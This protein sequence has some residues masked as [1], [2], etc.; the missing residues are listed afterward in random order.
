MDMAD[1]PDF[2]AMT[3]SEIVVGARHANIVLIDEDPHVRALASETLRASGH[4]VTEIEYRGTL[5]RAKTMSAG[6]VVTAVLAQRRAPTAVV[7]AADE[8]HPDPEVDGSMLRP[9]PQHVALLQQ[10]GQHRRRPSHLPVDP[11]QHHGGE[12]GVHGQVGHRSAP[13]GG[14]TALVDR[15]EPTQQHPRPFERAGRWRFDQREL[16]GAGAPHRELE[17]EA[18]EVG[19]L[20]LRH[21]EP[22]PARGIG[23]VPRAVRHPGPESTGPAGPLEEVVDRRRGRADT[24]AQEGHHHQPDWRPP[25]DE[26]LSGHPCAAMPRTYAA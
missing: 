8:P 17:R 15:A 22:W 6:L 26:L 14:T 16:V 25:A 2:F 3:G 18:G 7:A 12:P 11:R 5:G 4:V 10:R 21:R 13:C 20:D 24:P 1:K 9:T 23:R 19:H